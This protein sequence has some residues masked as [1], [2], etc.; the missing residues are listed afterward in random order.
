MT[1]GR[2]E[3]SGWSSLLW[4]LPACIHWN[5][6]GMALMRWGMFSGMSSQTW[7]IT[8]W[9]LQN[10]MSQSCLVNSI[11]AFQ[12]LLTH[13]SHMRPGIVTQREVQEPS[14][15]SWYPAPVSVNVTGFYSPQWIHHLKCGHAKGCGRQQALLPNVSRLPRPSGLP[16]VKRTRSQLWRSEWDGLILGIS[17]HFLLL[18]KSKVPGSNGVVAPLFSAPHHVLHWLQTINCSHHLEPIS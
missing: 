3:I 5:S 16:S 15:S 4:L 2:N 18:Q 10:S 14:P 11:D 8:Q 7:I 9:L 12:E 13:S 6:L 1:W 17:L